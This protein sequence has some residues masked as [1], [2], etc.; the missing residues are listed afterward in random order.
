MLTAMV[1]AI[2]YASVSDPT[3]SIFSFCCIVSCRK[4]FRLVKN[5]HVDESPLAK[6][7]F[8]GDSSSK[9]AKRKR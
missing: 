8:P 1:S 5:D 2:A 7:V 3:V 9:C 6:L 4:E